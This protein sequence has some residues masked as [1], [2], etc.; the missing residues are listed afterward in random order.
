[1]I[2]DTSSGVEVNEF[3]KVNRITSFLVIP[4]RSAEEIIGVIDFFSFDPDE[5]LQER[6]IPIAVTLGRE[7]GG[8]IRTAHLFNAAQRRAEEA[9]MLR[10]ASAAVTSAL[11]LDIVLNQIITTLEKVVPYDSCSI[12][13]N[14][15]RT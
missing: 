10:D 3:V 14:E 13:L 12:F 6:D 8:A 9:E 2:S 11:N 7:A 15:E 1:M 5:P 4:V